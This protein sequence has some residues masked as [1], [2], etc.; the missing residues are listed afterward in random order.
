MRR[1]ILSL[2]AEENSLLKSAS[3]QRKDQLSRQSVIEQS[4][5]QRHGQA[6]EKSLEKSLHGQIT[7]SFPK[8]KTER[9]L[10]DD[11]INL[12]LPNSFMV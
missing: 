11:E 6:N 12:N 5:A 3:E 9:P 8:R 10:F 1:D 2:L 7:K 4:K